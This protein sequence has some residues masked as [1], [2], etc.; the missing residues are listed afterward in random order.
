MYIQ[1]KLLVYN[2]KKTFSVDFLVFLLINLSIYNFKLTMIIK[3]QSNKKY[4]IT[5]TKN[6]PT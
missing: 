1:L 2:K 5:E 4:F 3:N 6:I